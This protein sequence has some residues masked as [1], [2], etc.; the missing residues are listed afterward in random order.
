MLRNLFLGAV[1]AVLLP[2]VGVVVFA[3]TPV[4]AA[5]FSMHVRGVC[6]VGDALNPEISLDCAC[7]VR[8]I[9]AQHRQAE[10]AAVF[11]GLRKDA[12]ATIVSL[13]KTGREMDRSFDKERN[14]RHKAAID[15]ITSAAGNCGS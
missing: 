15:I 7:I 11:E 9:E 1:L 8:G 12:F 3:V 2:V 10:M 6:V 5:N 4:T 13:V 14:S